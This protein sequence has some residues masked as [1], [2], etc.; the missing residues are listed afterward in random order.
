[1]NADR[2]FRANVL[3]SLGADATPVEKLFRHNDKVFHRRKAAGL[4][5]SLR[6]EPFVQ[7]WETYARE[8][9]QARSVSVL[10]SRL[11]QLSFPVQDG[12]SQSPEYV[13]ATR[14]GVPPASF[15]VANGLV[16]RQPRKRPV[17]IHQTLAGRIALLIDRSS[18]IRTFS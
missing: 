2:S 8:V 5:F 6:D 9:E 10:A 3:A 18:S 14:K 4:T 7:F 11:V 13:S 15:P 12:I 16:L 1:M 17:V